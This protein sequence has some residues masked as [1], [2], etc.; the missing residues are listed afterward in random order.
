MPEANGF[1]HS[2]PD[3]SSASATQSSGADST[4]Q[5]LSFGLLEGHGFGQVAYAQWKAACLRERAKLGAR[6]TFSCLIGNV[7]ESP[8]LTAPGTTL[9][10][11]H[12]P[13][14]LLKNEVEAEHNIVSRM[15]RVK[16]C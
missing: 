4:S 12:V 8:P 11:D 15:H 6:Q 9:Q 14:G 7:D 5:K 10:D 13:F 3:A 1:S 2:E 16:A